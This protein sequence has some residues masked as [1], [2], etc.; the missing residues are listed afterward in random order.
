MIVTTRFPDLPPGPETAANAGFR[1][2]FRARWGRVDS[3][4][5]TRASH[6]ETGPLPSSW[7]LKAVLD[8]S[9]ELWLDRRHLRLEPGRY[10]LVHPGRRYSARIGAA[11]TC[12]SLHFSP[13][14]VRQVATSHGLGWDDALD[15]ASDGRE[16]GA[17]PLWRE[18]IHRDDDAAVAALLGRIRARV[19][20]PAPGEHEEDFV[21]LVSLLLARECRAGFRALAR[22]SAVRS[23]TRDELV[24]RIGWA[25]DFI[26][27]HY[28]D[29]VDLARMA[30]A[31]HLSKFH[32]LRAFVELHGMTPADYLRQRRLEAARRALAG[33]ETDTA[34][35]LA[36]SG[37]GSRWSLQRALRGDAAAPG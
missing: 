11:S 15:A 14:L 23:T 6:V 13:A 34:A 7:S 32:F 25:T 18:Q 5:L 37:F 4:F 29:P 16:G 33:G 9:A 27:G 36:A 17:E 10:L 31:A 12:F 20:G 3:V 28:R 2:R 35:L 22:L 19:A 24:R 21:E 26:E 1:A 30:S 8:G